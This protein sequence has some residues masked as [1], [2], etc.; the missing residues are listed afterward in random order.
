MRQQRVAM[1]SLHL[2]RRRSVR[3]CKLASPLL[4]GDRPVYTL[5][6]NY[7]GRFSTSDWSI[8]ASLYSVKYSTTDLPRTKRTVPPSSSL[9]QLCFRYK[10]NYHF[11]RLPAIRSTRFIPPTK[12]LRFIFVD[13]FVTGIIFLKWRKND[14]IFCLITFHYVSY[15]QQ[16]W[17]SF[18]RLHRFKL[19]SFVVFHCWRGFSLEVVQIIVS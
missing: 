19:L 6:R 2:T 16:V 8:M 10:N 17:S 13:Y 3:W 12:S 15:R 11:F 7:S 14:L 9:F 18:T 5:P 1:G 4:R